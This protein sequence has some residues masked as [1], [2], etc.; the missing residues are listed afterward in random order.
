MAI[1]QIS[2]IQ[3]RTGNLVDLPQLDEAE[4]GWASDAKRLFIG[5]TTPNENIEVLTSYS[6]INFSQINGVVG[7]INVSNVTLAAGQVLTYDGS[8]WVNRGGDAGGLITLGDVSNVKIEGGAIG[9]VLETDGLGNLAWTPKSAVTASIQNVIE[10]TTAEV[11]TTDNN[12]FTNKSIVTITDVPN[13]PEISGN[14]FYIGVISSNRFGLYQ[15][16]NLSVTVNISNT[17]PYANVTQ[18]DSVTDRITLSNSSPFVVNTPVVFGGNIDSANTGID[19]GKVYYVKTEDSSSNNWITISETQGG[20]TLSIGTKTGLTGFVY[21]PGGRAL[22]TVGGAGTSAA[23]GSDTQVQYNQTGILQASSDF[24]FNSTSKVLSVNGNVNANNVAVTSVVTASRLV[25]TVAA[26]VAPPLVVTSTDRVANLNVSYA[27]VSDFGVVT[28]QTTGTYFPV[29]VG[30]SSTGNRSLGVN[31]NISFNAAT[32]DLSVTGNVTAT[33]IFSGNGLGLT[34][35]NA[36][37]LTTGTVA[38]ARLSG[39]YT[40][41]ISGN[42]TTAGTVTTSAQPNITSVGTLTTLGVN[43]TLTAANITAN[44]GVFTGNGAGLTNIAGGNVIGAVASATSAASATTAGTVTTAAQPNITSVGTLT[45]V[46][47]SGALTTAQITTGSSSTLGTITGNWT[48]AAGS[49]LQST[50]AD[51][52][53]YYDADDSYLP[54]TVLMFGGP[55]EVTLADDETRKVAGV[56]STSPAYVMNINCTGLMTPVALQGRVPCKVKG[57]IS[58]GD[59]MVSA[60]NGYAKA[61]NDPVLGSVIGKALEDFDGI[62]GVIEIAVGRL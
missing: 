13:I 22:S 24:T 6:T 14:S 48:L 5:K 55:N 18:T 28:A 23:A 27:N 44:T 33:G 12:F 11:I 61:I 26:G 4:F 15:D 35:L 39:S 19:S 37:N 49:R 34:S 59:M 32:G 53:E 21:V 31:A 52:A 8:E 2:K 41:D 7:N 9:Y 45:S 47:V 50:Y 40:I 42:A 43:G 25:S 20:S 17:F 30:S 46:S 54:G 10:T 36:T 60:G 16:A 51:L 57:K 1:L 29:F 62:T 3:Q 38:S 56:V 58:K